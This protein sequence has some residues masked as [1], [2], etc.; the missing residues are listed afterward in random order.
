[1]YIPTQAGPESS[2]EGS[3]SGRLSCDFHVPEDNDGRLMAG[4]A[5]RDAVRL[6]YG[7]FE[8]L[9]FFPFQV[10]LFTLLDANTSRE[11][12]SIES[13]L[14]ARVEPDTRAERTRYGPWTKAGLLL[15]MGIPRDCR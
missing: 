6:P 10:T 4:G 14:S 13:P 9:T 1:M 8:V 7:V 3:R 12:S 5:S 11:V 2:Y 15:A